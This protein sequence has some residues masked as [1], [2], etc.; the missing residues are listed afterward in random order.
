MPT[1][2]HGLLQIIIAQLLR[3][4]GFHAASEVELRI[5][6]EAHPRPDVVAT[7]S[8]PSEAY[9][10]KGLDI[11]IEIL[12]KDDSYPHLKD[13]CRRYAEW[14]FGHIFVVDPSDRSVAEW[15]DGTFIQV[16]DFVGITPDRIWQE[17]DR[18]YS[19]D[20]TSK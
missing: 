20:S 8:R 6:P 15:R 4:A 2:V 7:K 3:Q 19:A 1:W 9:P 18:E 11:V 16:S 5:I 12:S 14:G 13:K 17:L 10:S